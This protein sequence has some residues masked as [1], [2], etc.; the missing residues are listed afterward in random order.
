M[1]AAGLFLMVPAVRKGGGEVRYLS[2]LG[3]EGSD[4]LPIVLMFWFNVLSAGDKPNA[5]SLGWPGSILDNISL[6][7]EMQRWW[8]AETG[9]SVVI[10]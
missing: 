2:A 8:F 7:V 6:F 9:I 5:R 1:I 4:S 10:A 3:P